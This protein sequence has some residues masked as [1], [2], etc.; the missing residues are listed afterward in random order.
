MCRQSLASCQQSCQGGMLVC[1]GSCWE[2]WGST[3][4]STSQT[5]PWLIMT[6][7]GPA[8]WS[9]EPAKHVPNRRG[10]MP[11]QHAWGLHCLATL[12]LRWTTNHEAYCEWV[13]VDLLRRWH[14]RTTSSTGCGLQL[15]AE[16]KL[17][18]MESKRQQE[19]PSWHE[20]LQLWVAFSGL[21]VSMSSW[22]C[23]TLIV[24]LRASLAPWTP[25]DLG[26]RIYT[27]YS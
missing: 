15:A 20:F 27:T 17:E 24:S 14:L 4:S 8:P 2:G 6:G 19:Q 26:S 9:I 12:R 22:P 25:S 23:W 16:T 1:Q 21:K 7:N 10:T 11:Q 5:S 13:P 3:K 18:I